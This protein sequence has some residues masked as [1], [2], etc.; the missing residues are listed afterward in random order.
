MK[1]ATDS[2]P[3]VAA[4]GVSGGTHAPA[5]TPMPERIS[6]A[7]WKAQGRIGRCKECGRQDERRVSNA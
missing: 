7:E 2:V 3:P 4:A 5:R 1:D 6:I